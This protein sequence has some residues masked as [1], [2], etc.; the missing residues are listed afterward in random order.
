MRLSG[1]LALIVACAW[2][3]AEPA[4]AQGRRIAVGGLSAES[5]SLYPRAQPMVEEEP[6][7]PA[8]WMEENS[9]AS[10]VASGV[11]E[12]A[13]TLGFEV[14]PVLRAGASYLGHVEKASF[15]ENLD[16]LVDQIKTATPRFDGVILILHGAMV[17]DGYPHGD[18]EVVRRVREAMGE[19]FPIVVTHDFHA[20][21][22]EE[23]VQ[24]SDVL[25]TYKEN[26]HLDT[27]E[28]GIQAATILSKMLDG[29][30]KPVQAIVK[31]PM[32]VNI[33]Y[34]NTFAEPYK[35]V[36]DESRR[37]EATNPKILAV[38]VPGGYQWADVPAM[39]P[40]V[41][42]VTDNDPEL[43]EREAKRLSDML[44]NL[45]DRLVL[46][47]PDVATAVKDAMAAPAFPVV[48][49]DT[50][51]N[52]GGGSTG[53]GTFILAELVRQKAQGWVVV[54]SDPEANAAAFKA[55]IGG[56]FDEMVG[57]KTDRLHGDP[58]R[59]VGRV[60]ALHDGKYVE[61]EVRHGGGRYRDMGHTAV[62]EV[63]GSTTDLPNLLLLTN[64]PSSPNSLHQLISNGVYPERQRILVAKG[65]TAPRAAYEPIAARIVEVNSGGATDVNPRRFKFRH[66]R[67][68][69]FG[70]DK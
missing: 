21:V 3:V 13:G 29:T 44:W 56:A 59:I 64:S 16:K 1:T 63:E 33:V 20:N 48:L 10:T 5:N 38:S 57:G 11:I 4:A 68:G 65:T 31:P 53:D 22:S 2:A 27:K 17:V 32:I 25:I 62:I 9:K 41:I 28:R 36:T 14:H 43:A 50:G 58:V 30:V 39:G 67:R 26:P 37:L 19:G 51:D 24:Y 52:I 34:Q 23:I 35:A 61:P 69:L 12:A 8:L 46:R 55:G 18:A 45:R 49:M 60:K 54:I 70:I 47:V 6:R 15:E 42:V 40:S 7:D 66:I